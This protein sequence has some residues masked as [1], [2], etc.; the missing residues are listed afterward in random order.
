M[1]TT[2]LLQER[3]ELIHESIIGFNQTHQTQLSTRARQIIDGIDEIFKEFQIKVTDDTIKIS[4]E[5]DR[6][7]EFSIYRRQ[8]YKIDNTTYEKPELNWYSTTSNR[9]DDLKVLISLGLISKHFLNE[10]DEYKELIGLMDLKNEM[11]NRDIK[12]LRTQQYSI[13]REIETIKRE[14]TTNKIKNL[15]D[16]GKIEFDKATR[17]DY[18]PK[19]YDWIQSNKFRWDVNEGNKTCNLYYHVEVSSDYDSELGDYKTKQIVEKKLD[20]RIKMQ[21]LKNEI[22]RWIYLKEE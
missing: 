8:N 5:T 13:E 9:V 18:G 12:D 21:D 6:S 7:R 1:T 20:K 22:V 15:F 11:Y 16:L 19:R 4:L 2:Q 14:Q 3:L 17:F 10:T